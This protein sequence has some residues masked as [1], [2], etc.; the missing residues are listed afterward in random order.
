MNNFFFGSFFMILSSICCIIN[1]V[2]ANYF[3]GNCVELLFFRFLFATIMSFSRYKNRNFF[4]L[5]NLIRGILF[6]TSMFFFLFGLRRLPLPLVILINFAVPI[7][8]ILLSGIILKEKIKNRLIFCVINT[9]S[10]AYASYE[11]FNIDN[12]SA[13]MSLLFAS[14]LFSCIDIFNKIAINNDSEKAN[15]IVMGSSFF[16][17]LIF[18]PFISFKLPILNDIYLLIIISLMAIG[19]PFFM[20]KASKFSDLSALQPL[21]YLEFPMTLLVNYTLFSETIS[22]KLY[23]AFIMILINTSI[24]YIIEIK[25]IK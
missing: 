12:K 6:S 23:I 11:F 9:L 16:S 4:N 3:Y 18:L 2:C 22:N 7:W 10:I 15:D 19:I 24:S 20:L 13:I 25:T 17:T 5:N 14:F 21:K 8:N 1:D